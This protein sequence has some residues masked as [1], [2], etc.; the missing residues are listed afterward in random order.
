TPTAAL[1][2][3]PRS[4]SNSSARRLRSGKPRQAGMLS[5]DTSPEGHTIG[6]A[7]AT[8]TPSRSPGVTS[9]PRRAA[10][11]QASRASWPPPG[12]APVG[13]GPR[14]RPRIRPV[15]STTA[16]ASLVPPTS[17]ASTAAIATRYRSSP[18]AARAAAEGAMALLDLEELLAD[19]VDHRF[20]PG[21]Q[22]QLLEDVAGV[23]LD[24]VLRDLTLPGG[25][26]GARGGALLL[27]VG[28][29]D[30]GRELVQ[31]LGG[32]RRRDQGLALRDRADR[33]G[34]LLDRDLLEEVA[35]GA[36]LDGVIEVG[37]LVRDGQHQDLGVGDEVLDGRSGRA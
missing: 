14:P 25:F 21:V 34:D 24:G 23:V 4:A 16:A 1:W 9:A 37:F 19:R 31:E 10:A 15:S 22:V 27:L 28:P 18:G 20:H 17:R 36:G 30:H 13:E 32:H 11:A 33:V 2:I 6:P 26:G 3:R 8:P 12:P 29:L 5:G 7:A 35:V